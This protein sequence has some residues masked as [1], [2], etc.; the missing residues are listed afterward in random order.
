VANPVLRSGIHLGRAIGRDEIGRDEKEKTRR[1]DT[2][3]RKR[4]VDAW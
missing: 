4:T 2:T 3:D 1:I